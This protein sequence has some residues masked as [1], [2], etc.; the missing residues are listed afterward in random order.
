MLGLVAELKEFSDDIRWGDRC[1]CGDGFDVGIE[2]EMSVEEEGEEG[3][4][5]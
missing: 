2:G 1:I 5:G 4:V 3:L